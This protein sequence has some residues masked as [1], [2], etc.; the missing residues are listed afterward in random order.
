MFFYGNISLFL[1]S[2]FLLAW[3]RSSR[4]PTN[5]WAPSGPLT[6]FSCVKSFSPRH[7][8]W[9]F[10]QMSTKPLKQ[11]K[12]PPCVCSGV[13]RQAQGQG[14]GFAQVHGPHVAEQ[15]ASPNPAAVPW[16]KLVNRYLKMLTQ[17]AGRVSVAPHKAAPT[18]LGLTCERGVGSVWNG[19]MLP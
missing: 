9:P 2:L 17:G 10:C 19:P 18:K 5:L 6:V 8:P 1:R 7:P 16:T 11:R 12:F 13:Y 15:P 4:D 3:H 14:L